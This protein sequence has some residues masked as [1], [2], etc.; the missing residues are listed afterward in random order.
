MQDQQCSVSATV[1]LCIRGPV[2]EC[3]LVVLFLDVGHF[4]TEYLLCLGRQRL[5][6]VLLDAPQQERL[7]LLMQVTEARLVGRLVLALKVFPPCKPTHTQ[8]T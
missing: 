1:R 7:Q 4:H 3:S 8:C 2:A 6:H 5:L